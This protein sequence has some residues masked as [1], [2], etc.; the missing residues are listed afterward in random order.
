MKSPWNFSKFELLMYFQLYKAANFY[1]IPQEIWLTLSRFTGRQEKKTP[2][3]RHP[4]FCSKTD[5]LCL[6]RRCV[7]FQQ[8]Y[9]FLK[10]NLSYLKKIIFSH[11]ERGWEGQNK[12]V[13]I[14]M[15]YPTSLVPVEVIMTMIRAI[16]ID[17]NWSWSQ[18]RMLSFWDTCC[19]TGWP[20]IMYTKTAQWGTPRFEILDQSYQNWTFAQ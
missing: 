18:P 9:P 7:K 19:F 15:F 5:W 2:W 10:F 20:K 16:K 11:L 1:K 13:P 17:Q 4:I 14:L 8:P 3:V 12:S 6:I